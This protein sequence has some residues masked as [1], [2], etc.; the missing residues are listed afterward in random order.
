MKIVSE[1]NKKNLAAKGYKFPEVKT[2]PKEDPTVSI[3]RSIEKS[4]GID[5]EALK[6]SLKTQSEALTGLADIKGHKKAFVLIPERNKQGY[7]EKIT[8]QEI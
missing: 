7:I 2:E 8:I 6:E 3:L 5:R 1:K 4:L